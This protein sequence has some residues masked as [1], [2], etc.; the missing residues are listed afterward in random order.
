MDHCY[1]LEI[2]EIIYDGNAKTLEEDVELQQKLLG[3]G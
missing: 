2:G 1:V 3:V